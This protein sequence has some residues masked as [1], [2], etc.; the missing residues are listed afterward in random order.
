MQVSSLD[1]LVLTVRDIDATIAFYTNCLGMT[2]EQFTPVDGTRR[3]A[4]KF[5]VQKINLHVAGKEFSPRADIATPGSGDFCFLSDVD[6]A[7][8]VSALTAK[9]VEVELG[10]VPRTGA[11]GPLTSIY[12]RDPDGNLV[13]IANLHAPHPKT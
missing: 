3:V 13:E 1:H 9:G 12:L 10:P 11:T 6:V 8:W 2:A 4:L 5:G 7:D